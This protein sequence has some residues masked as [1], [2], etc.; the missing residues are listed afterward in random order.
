MIRRKPILPKAA[1][2]LLNL[3]TGDVPLGAAETTDGWAV[4]SLHGFHILRPG[5][6]PVVIP[7]Y[8]V[9]SLGMDPDTRVLQVRLVDG[10]MT[11]VP[12]VD[13]GSARFAMILRERVNRSI[14]HVEHADTEASIRVVIRR[15]HTGEFI[16]QVIGDGVDPDAPEFAAVTK[17]A[18]MLAWEAVGKPPSW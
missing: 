8:E 7:W 12:L 11:P 5:G 3:A 18:Q 13:G 4:A 9:D 15:D 17:A 16:M 1:A 10:S 14:V 2:Q 6:V